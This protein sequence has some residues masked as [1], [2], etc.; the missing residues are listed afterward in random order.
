MIGMARD[1]SRSGDP[2]H[3]GNR[4]GP[5]ARLVMAAD[6]SIKDLTVRQLRYRPH[7][8]LMVTWALRRAVH[9][10]EGTRITALFTERVC[11]GVTEIAE[12]SDGRRVYTFGPDR[13]PGLPGLAGALD[14]HR[15]AELLVVAGVPQRTPVTSLRIRAYRPMRR[16]VLEITAGDNRL[17]VKVVRPERSERLRRAHTDLGAAGVPVP[18]VLAATGDG[19]V[20]LGAIRGRSLRSVLGSGGA[21][22]PPP[23]IIEV[24]DGLPAKVTGLHTSVRPSR[25][26]REHAEWLAAVDTRF[27]YA[28][29]LA[30]R[31]TAADAVS[32]DDP[33]VAVHGDVHAKNIFVEARGISGL[34]DLDGV[35]RGRRVDEYATF[36]GHLSVLDLHSPDRRAAR[37][38]ADW[39]RHLDRATAI[40]RTGLRINV[41]AVILGLATG[42]YRV[43]EPSWSTHTHARLAL[44]ARWLESVATTTP[45]LSYGFRVNSPEG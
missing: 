14:R 23:Q 45:N 30:D 12:R 19:T 35:G 4:L 18:P 3:P 29:E 13:D 2:Y 24:L 39:M 1:G 42:C 44:A 25:R 10:P 16:A 15:L 28:I 32:A 31:I 34:V 8:S 11:D 38:G 9:V 27:E 6:P 33:V 7:R 5:L 36:L 21:V 26:V 40:D 41:A 20:V 22:P 43:Q 37:L 17:F